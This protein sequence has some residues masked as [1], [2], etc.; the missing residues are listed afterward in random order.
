MTAAYSA[1][2]KFLRTISNQLCTFAVFV[3]A[4]KG[5]TGLLSK[6]ARPVG[7]CIF[8][9]HLVLFSLIIMITKIPVN[10]N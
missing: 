8:S 2:E 6:T 4:V 9:I 5:L 1:T 10:G 7:A 3:H